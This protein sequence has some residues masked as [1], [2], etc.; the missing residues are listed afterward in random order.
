M[1]SAVLGEAWSPEAALTTST[2]GTWLPWC[3]LG[4]CKVP[5][6]SFWKS[7]LWSQLQPGSSPLLAFWAVLLVSRLPDGCALSSCGSLT[8]RLYCGLL[9]MEFASFYASVPRTQIKGQP[10]EG[11]YPV[12]ASTPSRRCLREHRLREQFCSPQPRTRG[13]PFRCALLP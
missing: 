10:P 13:S 3:F 4:G 5:H 8:F 1:P 9:L 7:F 6:V 2:R 12:A 11:A